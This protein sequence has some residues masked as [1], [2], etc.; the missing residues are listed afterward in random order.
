MPCS[1]SPLSSIKGCATS[2][3]IFAFL[4]DAAVQNMCVVQ[5][6]TTRSVA[7][8]TQTKS[9]WV[10]LTDIWTKRVSTEKA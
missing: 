1:H 10:M 4:A 8:S 6:E 2:R 5:N 3:V 7:S 9:N